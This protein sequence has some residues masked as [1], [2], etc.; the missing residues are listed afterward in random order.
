MMFAAYDWTGWLALATGLLVIVTAAMA[1]ETQ[2]AAKGASRAANA[3]E[4]DL[5]QG[6]Q[7]LAVSQQ[8]V[9]TAQHQVE[10][11]QEQAQIASGALVASTRPLIVPTTGLESF[12]PRPR[13]FRTIY[14]TSFLAEPPRVAKIFPTNL[15]SFP[16]ICIILAIRNIGPGVARFTDMPDHIL[17]QAEP[18][19]KRQ[20][21]IT[22]LAVAP[23][24]VVYV[25]FVER[26]SASQA[27]WS[28]AQMAELAK[29]ADEAPQNMMSFV[30]KYSDVTGKLWTTS[31]LRFQLNKDGLDERGIAFSEE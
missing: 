22:T 18:S 3:A 25:V 2:K 17:L 11:S 14:R 16:H 20:G 31:T 7:L 21:W 29:T 8:Q 13:H 28:L 10:A 4:Q 24:D 30:L 5:K 9:A 15:E 19:V 6:Q 1:Y 27:G 26:I 12:D 23:G